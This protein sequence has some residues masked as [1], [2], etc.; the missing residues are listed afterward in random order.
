MVM[1]S[2]MDLTVLKSVKQPDTNLRHRGSMMRRSA[3]I[4]F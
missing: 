2:W 3:A 1:L 4:P